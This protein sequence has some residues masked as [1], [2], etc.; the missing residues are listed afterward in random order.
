MPAGQQPVQLPQLPVSEP[1]GVAPKNNESVRIERAVKEFLADIEA[2]KMDDSTRRKYRTMLKQLRAY[3]AER[4]FVQVN[5]FT[6]EELTKFRGT[7]KD[8]LRSGAKKLERVRGFF[9]F[10]TTSC[11]STR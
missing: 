8:G 2:R 7:W 4:G 3:A 11:P 6:V 1:A 5:Q 10:M 9:R